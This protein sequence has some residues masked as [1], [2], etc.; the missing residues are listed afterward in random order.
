MQLPLAFPVCFKSAP[1]LLS[2]DSLQNRT[3]DIIQTQAVQPS[4]P[5]ASDRI[6]SLLPTKSFSRLGKHYWLGQRSPQPQ[7]VTASLCGLDRGE[8]QRFLEV[9]RNESESENR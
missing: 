1:D 3:D 5:V 9:P 7:T 4:R 2:G 8:L 6:D